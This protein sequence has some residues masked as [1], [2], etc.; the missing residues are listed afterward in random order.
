MSLAYPGVQNPN[1]WNQV[2][3]KFNVDTVRIAFDETLREIAKTKPSN[4]TRLIE[5]TYNFTGKEIRIS[6][7]SV[8]NAHRHIP[9]NPVP[10]STVR[11]GQVVLQTA[12]SI[13]RVMIHPYEMGLNDFNKMAYYMGE[14]TDA[15]RR[16]HDL[17]VLRALD[18]IPDGEYLGVIDAG[19]SDADDTD[20]GF[21]LSVTQ[22]IRNR[23]NN[24]VGMSDMSGNQPIHVVIHVDDVLN[25]TS[26]LRKQGEVVSHRDTGL[27]G[28][29]MGQQASIPPL[30][31]CMFHALGQY[32]DATD[33]EVSANSKYFKYGANAKSGA[34]A[35]VRLAGNPFK[36]NGTAAVDNNPTNTNVT[37]G[38]NRRRYIYAFMSKAMSAGMNR[39]PTTMIN[40]D[41]SYFVTSFATSWNYGVQVTHPAC[42]VRIKVPV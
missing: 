34:S 6:A 23:F 28:L 17:E 33:M 3:D 4:L 7:A 41:T 11:S 5:R 42:A 15:H 37:S 14:M 13:V 18:E 19:T 8:I 16:L 36:T 20:T 27:Y 31:G 2:V 9:G 40:P 22:Q 21:R 39:P 12:D 30:N 25:F 24:L 26:V 1:S 38:N 10:A 32:P 35:S 29:F